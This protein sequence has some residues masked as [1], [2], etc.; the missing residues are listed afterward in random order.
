MAG[1]YDHEREEAGIPEVVEDAEGESVPA[2]ETDGVSEESSNKGLKVENPDGRGNDIIPRSLDGGEGGE[3]TAVNELSYHVVN[4]D[5]SRQTFETDAH[6]DGLLSNTDSNADQEP[7]QDTANEMA[8]EKAMPAETSEPLDPEP[9]HSPSPDLG[10]VEEERVE[11]PVEE[12]VDERV[13]SGGDVE[14]SGMADASEPATLTDRAGAEQPPSESSGA[15]TGVLEEGDRAPFASSQLQTQETPY[16]GQP[17]EGSPALPSMVDDDDDYANES[18][19]EE[20]VGTPQSMTPAPVG[21]GLLRDATSTPDLVGVAL[22][23]MGAPHHGG[24]MHHGGNVGVSMHDIA[25]ASAWGS[26]F[27]EQRVPDEDGL[28]PPVPE[29]NEPKV[30]ASIEQQGPEDSTE[31]QV[32]PDN[33]ASSFPDDVV[34]PYPGGV[35][36]GPAHTAGGARGGTDAFME[37]QGVVAAMEPPAPEEEPDPVQ[38]AQAAEATG[39]AAAGGLDD[40]LLGQARYDLGA[41]DA[42]ADGGPTEGGSPDPD[43]NL[44]YG[45]GGG[46]A[47]DGPVAKQLGR[48]SG[49]AL[50]WGGG[51]GDASDAAGGSSW[52]GVPDASEDTARFLRL[53]EDGRGRAPS[54]LDTQGVGA[55]WLDALPLGG[56]AGEGGTAVAAGV[57]GREAK[58]GAG[59]RVGL[60]GGEALQWEEYGEGLVSPTGEEGRGADL[61]GADDLGGAGTA[62]MGVGAEGSAPPPEEGE[63]AATPPHMMVMGGMGGEEARPDVGVERGD[64]GGCA[65][66]GGYRVGEEGAGGAVVADGSGALPSDQREAGAEEPGVAMDAGH[67]QDADGRQD[68]GRDRTRM[69]GDSLA[70]DVGEGAGGQGVAGEGG[71]GTDASSGQLK[72]YRMDL[73]LG[74]GRGGGADMPGGGPGRPF[75]SDRDVFRDDDSMAG[76]NPLNDMGG[77]EFGRDDDSLAGGFWRP[78]AVGLA[79]RS[80]GDE[81][82]EAARQRDG[83]GLDGTQAGNAGGWGSQVEAGASPEDAAEGASLAVPSEGALSPQVRHGGRVPL[84]GVPEEGEEASASLDG[85]GRVRSSSD[86]AL[87][88]RAGDSVGS[89]VSSVPPTQGNGGGGSPDGGVRA[90]RPAPPPSDP[91]RASIAIPSDAARPS[92]TVP[93]SSGGASTSTSSQRSPSTL[94]ASSGPPKPAS[95]TAPSTSSSGGGGLTATAPSPASKGARLSLF[96][97]QDEEITTLERYLTAETGMAA[98]GAHS[99]HAMGGG[100]QRGSDGGL[101]SEDSI[102][103]PDAMDVMGMTPEEVEGRLRAL[104]AAVDAE[105]QGRNEAER[106]AAGLS[107]ALAAEGRTREE[108][109]DMLARIQKHFKQEQAVRRAAE[110]RVRTLTQELAQERAARERLQGMVEDAEGVQLLRKQLE[111]QRAQMARERVSLQAEAEAARADARRAR[112]QVSE[113]QERVYTSEAMERMRLEAEHAAKV[114]ALVQEMERLQASADHSAAYAKAEVERYRQMAE[115]ATDVVRAAKAELAER[116]RDL[117]NTKDK[118]DGLVENLY[119]KRDAGTDLHREIEF[120]MQRMQAQRASE[121]AAGCSAANAAI[122]R[123]AVASPMA[124]SPTH[125]PPGMPMAHMG[126]AGPHLYGED[127]MAGRL[128][129]PLLRQIS[130]TSPMSPKYPPGVLLSPMGAALPMAAANSPHGVGSPRRFAPGGAVPSNGPSSSFLQPSPPHSAPPPP[131]LGADEAALRLAAESTKLPKVRTGAGPAQAASPALP[132]VGPPRGAEQGG[133]YAGGQLPAAPSNRDGGGTGAAG[134]GGQPRGRNSGGGGYASQAGGAQKL[135][136]NGNANANANGAQHDRRKLDA[137]LKGDGG[138]P[139]SPSAKIAEA[140]DRD[141]AKGGPGKSRMQP[142]H[143]KG[144]DDRDRFAATKQVETMIAAMAGW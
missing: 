23:H 136:G 143:A 50:P 22:H 98:G 78:S 105:R 97:P 34:G 45:D 139:Y 47:G 87:G 111:E 49:E 61:A 107:A 84:E 67:A 27:P 5:E 142:P 11:V 93:S 52:T 106:G 77:S 59:E 54:V 41:E 123:G 79:V 40:G 46:M 37:G 76:V 28:A 51:A 72:V 115:A 53:G 104:E 26:S 125:A 140:R 135:A 48:G 64:R 109:E 42:A 94:A 39:D 13:E 56:G 100:R 112:E 90:S 119:A 102:G 9:E 6:E 85:A 36:E 19:A 120:Q 130:G 15:L 58:E 117:D 81:L 88:V 69:E 124:F 71:D 38:E 116:R 65:V 24:G 83:Y 141:K 29:Y 25:D 82:A 133:G 4:D 32:V 74:N 75:G 43:P 95:V 33:N 108:L 12:L 10:P 92:V 68:Q 103:D 99:G 131:P 30:S 16:G 66:A 132:H 138:V 3:T 80:E 57:D 126:N 2:E 118:L 144:P 8:V 63:D 89:S 129:P 91:P 21:N 110:E 128:P 137:S 17:E 122:A 134:G 18:F 101:V 113:A 96:D 55:Q 1:S 114:S 127:A 35:E 121:Y 86:P 7:G 73:L 14:V 44:P 62:A 60:V 20:S 70:R 31:G